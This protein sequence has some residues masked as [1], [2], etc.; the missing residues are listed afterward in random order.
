M[1]NSSKVRQ[2]GILIVTLYL[3]NRVTYLSLVIFKQ[4]LYYE[5]ANIIDPSL[6]GS[7]GL[8]NFLLILVPFNPYF[9]AWWSPI[10]I[11]NLVL[12]FFYSY[13]F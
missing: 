3:M 6:K 13:F 11:L 10:V 5:S 9:I 2:V 8:E 7:I 4:G 1:S 12:L